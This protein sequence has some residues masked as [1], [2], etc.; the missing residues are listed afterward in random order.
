MNIKA[1]LTYQ[2]D[3]PVSFEDRVDGGMTYL[4]Y[5]SEGSSYYFVTRDDVNDAEDDFKET[6]LW[7]DLNK[8]FED[9]PDMYELTLHY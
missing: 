2:T 8:A 5:T 3:A 7:K 6:Q 4:N 9:N 1:V